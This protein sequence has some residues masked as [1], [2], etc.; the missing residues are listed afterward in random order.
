MS[1]KGTAKQVPG[2][3]KVSAAIRPEEITVGSAGENVIEGTVQNAEYG[4]RDSLIDVVTASG[5]LIHARTTQ[6]VAIGDTVKLTVPAERV[7]VYPAEA[8][9]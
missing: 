5:I 6:R 8:A 2:G 7:L 3:K 4:G 9:A 1:L